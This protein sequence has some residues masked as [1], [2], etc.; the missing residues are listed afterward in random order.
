MREISNRRAAVIALARGNGRAS[1]SRE[2]RSTIRV[3]YLNFPRFQN[4]AQ[5][6]QSSKISLRIAFITA[7]PK[8]FDVDDTVSILSLREGYF[9]FVSNSRKLALF[10]SR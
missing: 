9:H 10:F 3:S 5:R 1:C 6:D 7:N 2:Y 4:P 8:L